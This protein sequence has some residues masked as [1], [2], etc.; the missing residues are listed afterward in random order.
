MAKDP[1]FIFYPGD[2]LRDTQCLSEKSQVAYD[3]IMCEHMRN[4]LI[5]K[6]QFDFFTKKLTDDEKEELLMTLTELEGSYQISWVVESITKRKAFTESR[7]N[8]RLKSDEDNVRIYIVR[9]N[10]RSIY[11]IGSSVNPIR[12]YNELN[13]QKNP[14]IMGDDQNNRDLTLIWYS[15]K[16]KRLVETKLHNTFKIKNLYG[17][18]FSLIKSDIIEIIKAYGGVTYDKTYVERTENE[19]ENDN[20][21]IVDSNKE[22]INNLKE[23]NKNVFENSNLFR[24]PKIP[25]KKEVLEVFDRSV[26]DKVKSKKMARAFWDK[27]EGLGWFINGSPVVNF[28]SL[29]NK[30]ITNW[31]SNNE[32][33][34]Y[35]QKSDFVNPTI[36]SEK[37][38]D[39][40]KYRAKSNVIS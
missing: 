15:D 31:N 1:G 36:K 6:K 13:N 34:K 39:F 37:E 14:A 32:D 24:Q 9:D 35:K 16:V 29:A 7:R 21:S 17:E 18:W 23:E 8:S 26:S 19:I 10:V 40:D 38:I 33:N 25:T 4:T 22:G 27:Y 11:K 28:A 2:Y 20:N 12:R 5:S 30:F 3:R